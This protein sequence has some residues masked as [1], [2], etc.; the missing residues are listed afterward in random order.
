MC[1]SYISTENNIKA[2][3]ASRHD[4]SHLEGFSRVPIPSDAWT[5]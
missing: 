3:E 4:L 1:L 2:D 5:F